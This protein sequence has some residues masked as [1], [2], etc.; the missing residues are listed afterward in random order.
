MKDDIERDKRER[1]A[2]VCPFGKR[3]F[4]TTNLVKYCLTFSGLKKTCFNISLD[5]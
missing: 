2:K 1:A 3:S 4:C 5:L